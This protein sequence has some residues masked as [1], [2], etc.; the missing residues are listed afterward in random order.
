MSYVLSLALSEHSLNKYL[1]HIQ[2]HYPVDVLEGGD[3]VTTQTRP[4]TQPVA[5]L[6]FSSFSEKYEPNLKALRETYPG[7]PLIV[8]H[9]LEH[10]LRQKELVHRLSDT[11]VEHPIPSFIG[12]IIEAQIKKARNRPATQVRH[13]SSPLEENV[14]ISEKMARVMRIA[15]KV[16]P[17]D[18]TI[19]LTGESG[20][21]KEVT[22]NWIHNHSLRKNRPFVAINCGAITETILESELFGH[23]KGSF[24]GADRDK[25]GLFEAADSGTLFLDEIGEMPFSLQVK[26]LR[27]LQ[28]RKIRK[29]GDIED[30]PV[31]VRIIAATNKNLKQL[32]T[33]NR[34]REDLYYR[35]NVVHLHLPPLRERREALPNMIQNFV[36]LYAQKY[37]KPVRHLTPASESIL[38]HYGYPG[39]IRE[40]Q[41]ILEFAV[42]MSEGPSLHPQ[43]L[44][45]ELQRDAPLNLLPYP[46]RYQTEEQSQ[47]SSTLHEFLA[48]HYQLN[49]PTI[50]DLE[51][52]LIEEK[53]H[54]FQENQK[55]V[56]ESLGISRTSLWR[57]IKEYRIDS[58]PLKN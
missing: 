40:L 42:I 45:V 4:D 29:V 13:S 10:R 54:I 53:L 30:I 15:A 20:T 49:Q 32:V 52:L 36:M 34:F 55:Q 26:L 43:D 31:N 22:A 17:T 14:P 27:V 11:V 46:A 57:K 25:T 33:E 8:I 47:E 3:P 1:E 5:I 38:M 12:N 2:R 50:A 6:Y 28:E 48:R 7:I 41:N 9:D 18:A 21:G 37:A 51:K 19:L 44:P 24:T 56:A 16:A 35:L 39:N 58:R 23:K